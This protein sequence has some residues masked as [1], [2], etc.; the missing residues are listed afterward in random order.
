MK[1]VPIPSERVLAI[2]PMSRGFGYVVLEH[3]PLR[4]ADWGFASCR[5]SDGSL[6]ERFSALARRARPTR[7][8]LEDPTGAVTAPRQA[9]LQDVALQVGGVADALRIPVELVRRS[10][11]RA[12]FIRMGAATQE[13]RADLLVSMFPEL[14]ARRP[15]RRRVFDSEDARMAVFDALALR[16]ACIHSPAEERWPP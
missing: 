6:R 1:Y 8:V 4:L 2:D 10:A 3:E 12:S 5:R 7:I 14:A 13:A 11:V 15:G 9:V 16:L